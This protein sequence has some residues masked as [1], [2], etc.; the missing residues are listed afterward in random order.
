MLQENIPNLRHGHAANRKQTGIYLSWQN[1]LRRCESKKCKDY[2]WYGAR[3]ISVCARWH[4]FEHFLEDMGPNWVKGLTLERIDNDGNYGPDNCRW[5]TRK[6]Q[7][8][9]RRKKGSGKAN[10]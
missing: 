5:A 9:N 8:S 2:G 3:G 7:A 6:Q 10:N 1:M 4:K